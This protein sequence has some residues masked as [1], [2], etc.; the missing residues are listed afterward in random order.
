MLTRKNVIINRMELSNLKFHE[1]IV[2]LALDE[3]K[4]NLVCSDYY[5]LY[6]IM[7]AIITELLITECISIDSK[8]KKVIYQ[9]PYPGDNQI[10]REASEIISSSSGSPKD[11]TYWIEHLKSKIKNVIQRTV[12]DLIRKGILEERQDKFLFFKYKSYPSHD[13]VT[14]HL[15]KEKIRYI[16]LNKDNSDKRL[17]V[18]ARLANACDLFKVIFRPDEL[19]TAS[20]NVLKLEMAFGVDKAVHEAIE[21]INSCMMLCLTTTVITATMSN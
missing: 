6:T 7:G 1:Q 16:V 15:L 20:A 19:R 9:N 12:E 5:L 17:A 21:A 4:G 2:M 11:I 10:L 13:R 3:K 8:T 18:V 14:E